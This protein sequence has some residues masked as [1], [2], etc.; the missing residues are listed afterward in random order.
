M[1]HLDLVGAQLHGWPLLA[2]VFVTPWISF[3][4]SKRTQNIARVGLP[5][6]LYMQTTIS[7]MD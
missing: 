6:R 5:I 4:S 3:S 1:E 2:G 7:L